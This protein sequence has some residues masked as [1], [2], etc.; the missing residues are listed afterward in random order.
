MYMFMYIV[1]V[2][3][4]VELQAEALPLHSPWPSGLHPY[5]L[6]S[7][8]N[9]VFTY[10]CTCKIHLFCVSVLYFKFPNKMCSVFDE[11]IQQ[12]T[13]YMYMHVCTCRI[14]QC[15]HFIINSRCIHVYVL[16]VVFV[17]V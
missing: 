17:C 12:Y 15:C 3:V 14:I 13:V 5:H 1:R 4:G 16:H 11:Y 6:L 9:I 2:G 7:Q 10:T 8:S